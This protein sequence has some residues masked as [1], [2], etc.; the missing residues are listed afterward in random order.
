ML[1]APS[2]GPVASCP[3]AIYQHL[4]QAHCAGGGC[5][6]PGNPI[7]VCSDLTAAVA[8]ISCGEKSPGLSTSL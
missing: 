8:A 2:D 7:F 3:M 4:S 6:Q 1:T 5:V